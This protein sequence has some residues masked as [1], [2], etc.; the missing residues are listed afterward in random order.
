[1]RRI[2]LT[3]LKPRWIDVI[4]IV[5]CLLG[6]LPFCLAGTNPLLRPRVSVADQ[7]AEL[8]ALSKTAARLASAIAAQQKILS[9]M[10]AALAEGAVQLAPARDVNRRI[11]RLTE[12]AARTGLEVD[13]VLPGKARTHPKYDTVP[14]HVLAS[15]DYPTCVA[16]LSELRETFPDTSVGSFE[17]SGNPEDPKAPAKFRIDLCWY[18]AG[19][20]TSPP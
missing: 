17:L 4:G 3:T 2:G 16:F 12:I 11:A 9:E 18:A 19:G 10:R 15:G 14:F 5:V 8:E 20:R 1:M 6:A 7:R 13:E